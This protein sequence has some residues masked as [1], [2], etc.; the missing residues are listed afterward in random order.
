MYI[1]IKKQVE[2]YQDKFFINC[3]K[4]LDYDLTI[5]VSKWLISP[6]QC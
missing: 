3:A 2:N 4:N 5:Q 1:K 6:K